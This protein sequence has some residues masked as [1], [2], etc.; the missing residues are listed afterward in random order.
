M[1][2]DFKC[3]FGSEDPLKYS[4]LSF[5][6]SEII[7]L[8][9]LCVNGV[10]WDSSRMRSM[11]GAQETALCIWDLTS[12][13]SFSALARQ[14]LMALISCSLAYSSAHLMFSSESSL[15]EALI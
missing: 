8:E 3:P 5:S 1:M 7:A 14:S 9:I 2:N 10:L 4:I 12:F 11:F 15:S 6:G 13:I